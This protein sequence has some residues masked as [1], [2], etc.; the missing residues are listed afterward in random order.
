LSE[1]TT[2]Y[3][4][5]KSKILEM[6]QEA[7]VKKAPTELRIENSQNLYT[8]GCVLAIGICLLPMLLLKTT[9]SVIGCIEP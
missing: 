1:V 4:D 6:V 9:F 5:S 7:A 3:T 2:A 8:S